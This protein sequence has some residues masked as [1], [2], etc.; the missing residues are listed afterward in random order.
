MQIAG[1]ECKI[2]GRSIIIS[3]EGKF[4]GRC[5]TVVHL[6]CEAES[7]CNVCGTPYEGYER[8]KAAPLSEAIVPLAVRGANRG[9]SVAVALMVA[10]ALLFVIFLF[11]M[12]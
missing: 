6:S 5:G 8:P 7:K 10:L 4:C 9:W 1:N 12:F 11:F 3:N 2:C